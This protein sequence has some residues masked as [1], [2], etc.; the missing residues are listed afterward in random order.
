MNGRPVHGKA[1][2]LILFALVTFAGGVAVER[3]GLLPRSRYGPDSPHAPFW[4]AWRVVREHYVDQPAAQP[5]PMT[6]G[7]IRGMVAFLGDTGH[8]TYLSP[9]EFAEMTKSLQGELEGIG[10]RL[11]IRAG[12]PTI[13]QTFPGSPARKAGIVPGD[14]LNTVEGH[15]LQG[16]SLQKVVELVRGPPGSSL[17]LRILRK[18]V[19]DPLDITLHRARVTIPNVSW[20]LLP[21]TPIA[22]LAIFE[23]GMQA[24]EQLRTALQEARGQGGRGLILDVRGNPGGLTDQAVAVTSE[25]LAGGSVFVEQD[26]QGRRT[27]VPVRAGGAATQIPL[28]VLIDQGTASSA[29]IFAGAIQDHQRGKL[30]GVRTFGTGTVLRPFPLRDGSVILLAI[31]Q[32]LTPRGRPIWHRGIAPDIDVALPENAV[33]VIPEQEGTW[34]AAALAKCSDSQLLKA[35]ELLKKEVQ[36]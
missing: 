20:H 29:E 33:M 34:D 9:E 24:D 16:L 36:P 17:H 8:S 30:I 14:V 22:H 21:D 18:G 7:S 15:N 32:W 27:P 1:L 23:F 10:A 2:A 19:A 3:A 35:M 5:G 13:V 6:E 11:T 26:A 12:F 28:C 25:F 4:E 31:E